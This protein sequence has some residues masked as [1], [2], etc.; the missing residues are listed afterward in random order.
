MEQKT[1]TGPSSHHEFFAKLYG[2]LDDLKKGRG[3]NV[4]AT[5]A[6]II[7]PRNALSKLLRAFRFNLFSD[8][9]RSFEQFFEIYL[10]MM[11]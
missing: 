7:K 9:S 3:F 4:R 2:G 6:L 1:K 5:I 10:A 8:W 11:G